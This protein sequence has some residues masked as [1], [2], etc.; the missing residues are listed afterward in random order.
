MGI[1]MKKYLKRWGPYNRLKYAANDAQLLYD[2]YFKSRLRNWILDG[3]QAIFRQGR[4]AASFVAPRVV[5][6]LPRRP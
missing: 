5:D 1:I 6:R 3:S 2:R 4:A